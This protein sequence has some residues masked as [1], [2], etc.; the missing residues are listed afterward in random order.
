MLTRIGIAYP[1]G[2]V[3]KGFPTAREVENHKRLPK[4][5]SILAEYLFHQERVPDVARGRKGF[6]A[7]R[8]GEK[9]TQ[10]LM[11]KFGIAATPRASSYIYNTRED[12]DQ[13]AEVLQRADSLFDFKI[14]SQSA[15]DSLKVLS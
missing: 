13:L 6:S 11:R 3:G 9:F 4:A 1:N 10:P 5:A 15:N 8:G 2:S 12:V 14:L 7:V